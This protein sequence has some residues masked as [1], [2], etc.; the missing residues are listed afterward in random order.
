M[1]PD[2]NGSRD[3]QASDDRQ[4]VQLRRYGIAL[5]VF[6]TLL[7]CASL[8][9]NLRQQDEETR[10]IAHAQ[11]L[12]Y[13]NKDQAFRLWASSHGGVYVPVDEET[14][15][16]PYLKH[17][18][19][20][21]I[22]KPNGQPMTL[23]N[24]AYMVRQ[25]NEEFAELYGIAGHITSQKPVRPGNKPDAWERT[26]LQA[27]ERG[28]KEVKEFAGIDGEPYLRLMRPM[29]AEKS[30]LKCHGHQGYKEG[31][32]RGGVGVSLPLT[33]LLSIAK[34]HK[35]VISVW[36]GA[37]WLIGM[38]G[39]IIGK[40]RLA[41]GIYERRRA[42]LALRQTEMLTR[43]VIDTAL[44]AVVNIDSDGKITDWNPQAET[45]FGWTRHQAIG[46]RLE[47]TIIPPKYRDTH[48]QGLRNYLKTGDGPILNK[49]IE[50]SAL[51]KDG[52]E[53]PVEL[54]I[55]PLTGGE[56]IIFSAFVRDVTERKQSEQAL[57]ESETLYRSLIE[58][59]KTTPW[60]LD[61]RTEAFTYIGHQVEHLLGYKPESWID[62]ETWTERIHADDREQAVRFCGDSTKLCQDH[63][64]E[65][66]AIAADGHVV[67]I[68]DFVTVVTDEKG[69]KE[70]VGFMFDITERKQAEIL[71][72]AVYQIAQAAD[73]AVKLD[74]LFP[75]IHEI[76][77]TVMPAENF[78]IALLDTKTN[79]IG[80]PYFVD[81]VSPLEP[82]RKP[83]KG[84]TE[85]VLETGEPQLINLARQAE[86]RQ[87]QKI[88]P[89]GESPPIWLGVPLLV[90]N[91]AIGVMAV[92]HYSNP[93]AYGEREKR[94]LEFVSSQVALAIDRKR[95]EEKLNKLSVAL[96]Q[97]PVM[98]VVTDTAGKIE[99]V[100]PRF[101]LE[102]G[103]TAEEV[104]GENPNILKSGETTSDEY[105]KMW[106]TITRGGEWRGEFHNKKKNGELYWESAAI[107]PIKNPDGG[108]TH[109]LA[110]K[111][112]ITDR[113][114]AEAERA[115]LEEQL[116]HS[117]KMETI[118]TLAGGI[119]HDFNNILQAI[120]GYVDMSLAALAPKSQVHS[121]LNEVLKAT[122]RA[123]EMVQQILVFS[124]PDIQERRPARLHH[125]VNESIS[126]LKGPIPS[127]I[128]IRHHISQACPP[129]LA[130]PGQI[131]Q[132]VMNLCTNA[133]QAMA[134]DGGTL[135]VT[136]KMHSPDAKLLKTHGG[137]AERKFAELRISDT[138]AGISRATQERIFE[139]FFTTKEVGE[140]T[141]LGL[142][143]VHGIVTAHDG[144][145]VVESEPDKG[146]TFRVFLP[147]VEQITQVAVEAGEVVLVGQERILYVDDEE[148]VTKVIKRLLERNGYEVTTKT[149][150]LAALDTFRANPS[151]FDL[152]IT[153]QT[154]PDM[155]GTDLAKELTR[156]Q[157]D[158]PIILI[159]G[160]A[161]DS[162]QQTSGRG[163]IREVVM[164][165][166][167]A[168]ELCG[169]IR[170]VM[171]NQASLKEEADA[172]NP[173]H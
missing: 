6:W 42:E 69:P 93:E 106:Q 57:R 145:V 161:A 140:G 7:L 172:T 58:S 53:F 138:G 144:Y 96:E 11:A 130:C 74:D 82:S 132:V 108:T 52:H 88:E 66:R 37:L 111:E 122:Q 141:G 114:T 62:M 65:Y 166:V 63:D 32:I 136:L 47:E 12:A 5:G 159:S 31:D 149:S 163:G 60:R 89:V 143:V 154:M 29:V 55:T 169:T 72:T 102:T 38:L 148:S 121:D 126:L 107:S 46:R 41:D 50:I 76:V 133:Y 94:M 56:T 160:F 139:P 95:A 25:M 26:A 59:T 35:D 104:I 155:T 153:D 13:F 48:Q 134:K 165:P 51:R 1:T 10:E 15:P 87:E 115:K 73:R 18:P 90:E 162:T 54:T 167:I 131:H 21:D 77:K 112:N 129:V 170:K 117:Q 20:R 103:Y 118:G 97:S 24:P 17:I 116:R 68:R 109:F 151:S 150:S 105:Q 2:K 91:Q 4:A 92:Q 124:R 61:L 39:L 128:K 147:V 9:W 70:L 173:N 14:P 22:Q 80:F 84:W 119:A 164:K 67:W 158:L 99:Y 127:T 146:T 30:C 120:Y 64:F 71:Q 98:V 33:P 110:V 125:I 27:F 135:T 137:L 86:L 49:R 123:K 36:H 40:R 85:Y 34:K 16:N 23:M 100:N 8:Y 44:D 43:L 78:Y 3:S 79:L 142:S 101:T 28:E 113:K 75:A 168:N 19:D 157:P 83:G 171:D 152:V 81:E 45:T 156:T